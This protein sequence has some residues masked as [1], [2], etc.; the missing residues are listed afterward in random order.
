MKLAVYGK[1]G[2][3]K[4]TIGCNLS[5]A[6]AKRGKRVLQIGCDPKHDSTFTL[7]GFL[8]PTIVDT[9]QEKNYHYED[10][11]VE[12]VIYEGYSGVDCVES[13]GPPAGAG[14]GGYVVG[15]TVKLLKEINAFYE[16]DVILF[17]VL[18]DVV[19]GGF[20]APLNYSD[21]CLIITDNG[22][23]A[24]Y[25]ANRIVASVREKA[26]THPL[27]L[28]G[29]IGNRT[30]KRNLIDKYVESCPIPVLEIIPIVDGIQVSRMQGQT[31][32]EIAE[33]EKP[34]SLVCD[35][36]L[37]IAD[38]LLTQPEGVVPIE[39]PDQELFRLLSN[40]TS[41]STETKSNLDFMLV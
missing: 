29:L 25:A 4:S 3:G 15:E 39:L 37:N 34:L 24:L 11:W 20:A 21:Y 10:I 22:F 16:Y 27:K 32:F 12:D 23:E 38:Q 35:F 1:G 40:T 19:C 2:V 8:I 5:I 26:R 9:L 31:V 28:A 33:K 41:K 14:C 30:R 36:Y 17:D 7:A 6:L 18:G 13:G